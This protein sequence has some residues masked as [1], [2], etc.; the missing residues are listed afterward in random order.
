MKKNLIS[1]LLI[2]ILLI[3]VVF[4]IP[5]FTYAMDTIN[6]EKGENSFSEREIFQIDA[7]T[8]EITKIDIDNIIENIS[9]TKLINGELPDYTSS[10]TPSNVLSI[11]PKNYRA[12]EGAMV[13]IANTTYLPYIRVCKISWDGNSSSGFMV[14]PNL[15]LTAAHCFLD[16]NGNVRS[17]WACM[18]AYDYGIYNNLT[19]GWQRAYF[20]PYR[21]TGD[22]NDD[23]CVVELDWNMGDQVGWF[24]CQSYGNNSS[25]DNLY[26]HSIGY[27]TEPPYT[28]GNHQ[29]YSPGTIYNVADGYFISNS[30]CRPG[31]SGGPA[32]MR[33]ND[34]AIGIN[35]SIHTG[36]SPDITEFTRACKIHGEIIDIILTYQ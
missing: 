12:V 25:Y 9:D 23:W 33:S 32:V 11:F 20:G 17:G 28:E 35:Q 27:P 21:T 3:Y 15:V 2:S 8:N 18:P 29:Y 22:Y 16:E 10:Y 30:G 6:N 13:S 4:I 5:N 24:G 36:T 34:T 26:I 31:M 7:D 1:F 14:A 19:S